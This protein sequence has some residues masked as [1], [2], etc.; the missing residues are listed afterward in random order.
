MLTKEQIEKLNSVPEIRKDTCKE[1]LKYFIRTGKFGYSNYVR[2]HYSIG[3]NLFAYL[4]DVLSEVNLIAKD[5][6][7]KRIL[8]M[9]AEDFEQYFAEGVKANRKK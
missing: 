5:E 3:Y 7:N 8:L 4:Q 2:D 1:V 9:T 6:E